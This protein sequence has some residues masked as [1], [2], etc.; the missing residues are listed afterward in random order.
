MAVYVSFAEGDDEKLVDRIGDDKLHVDLRF[1]VPP[2]EAIDYFKRKQSVTKKE[3]KDLSDEAKSSAFTISGIYQTDVLDGFKM[4]ITDAL[5]SG[6][7]QQDV[8]KKFKGILSGAGHKELGDFHLETVFRTNMMSAYGIGKRRAMEE[9]AEDLPFWEYS[10]V[11]DDRTRPTHQALDGIVLPYDH[12]FWQTHFPPWEFNCRCGANSR[13]SLPDDYDP[14]NP[15][16][17]AEIIYDEN[18][19]PVKA[20]WQTQVLDLQ[21][22]KFD[23]IPPQGKLSSLG[24]MAKLRGQKLNYPTPDAVIEQEN[25]I[26]HNDL[27]TVSFHD[28]EGNKLFTKTGEPDNVKFDLTDVQE[29]ILD[30]SVMTHNH[31]ASAFSDKSGWQWK[32]VSFSLEDIK[33]AF[34]LNLAEVRAVGNIFRYTLRPG[35]NGWGEKFKA[36]IETAHKL[37]KAET[38]LELAKRIQTGEIDFDYFNGVADHIVWE[39]LAKKYNLRYKRIE[40]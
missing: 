30:K 35:K 28:R 23:G 40:N 32:G 27:E 14:K 26:R 13:Y 10:A 17:K 22:G 39:K 38:N 8:I 5:E 3:F 36:E 2:D 20:E 1:D 7:S 4:E 16:G 33:T 15:S 25:K 19:T 34:S 29:K 37:M 24:D 9:V 6:R 21:T 18:E 31:P 12:P 11:G